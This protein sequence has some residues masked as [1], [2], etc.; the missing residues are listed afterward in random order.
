MNRLLVGAVVLAMSIPA[1]SCGDPTSSLRGG[2]TRV[3]A[4]PT[5]LFVT[6]GQTGRA[7]GRPEGHGD[8]HQS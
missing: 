4:D 5:S 3:E 8:V 2:A 1:L 6:Q 7:E